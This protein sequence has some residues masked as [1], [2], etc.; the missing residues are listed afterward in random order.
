MLDY[1]FL[2]FISPEKSRNKTKFITN[3]MRKSACIAALKKP[4]LQNTR[5]V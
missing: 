2:L 4:R 3:P 1:R 5:T